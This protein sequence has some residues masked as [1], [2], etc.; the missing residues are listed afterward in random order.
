MKKTTYILAGLA[1]LLPAHVAFGAA[2]PE[3]EG[4]PPAVAGAAA[5]ADGDVEPFP[6]AKTLRQSAVIGGKTVS[7]DVTVGALPMKDEKG[8]LLGEVVYTAYTLPG[9]GAQRPVT[10][11]FN[12][13]P[14]AA[15]AY[16]NLGVLGPKVVRFGKEG[17]Y[18]SDSPA[19]RDNPNSW[20]EFTDLVF[21]DPVGTGFSRIRGDDAAA[22][23]KAFFTS[24]GD[25]QYLSR[26]IYDWLQNNGRMMSNKYLIGESYGGYRVPRIARYLQSEVGVGISGITMVSPY[27]DPSFS[28]ST[29]SFSPVPYV[30]SLPSMAATH[31]ESQGRPL[32]ASTMG[33]V[34]DYASGEFLHDYLAGAKD[35]A[36][37]ARL[38][39]KVT[40]FTGLDP[41]LVGKLDG[42]IDAR[43]FVREL[44]RDQGRI[45]SFYDPNVTTLDPYPGRKESEYDDPLLASTA[46]FSQA[47]SDL[48]VSQIGWKVNA[49]YYINNYDVN[50][51]FESDTGE[52]AVVDLRKAVGTDPRMRAT[53]VHGWNDLACPYFASKLL[54]AQMPHEG[55]EARVNLHVYPGGHMF[56]ARPDSAVAF[57][58]DMRPT[59]R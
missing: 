26:T 55:G 21:I 36:A 44:R 13:G 40:E 38:V 27:L 57:R 49:R 29:S 24:E 39:A 52:S 19:L 11:S 43:T 42:R 53:I 31:F 30:A 4:A 32:D 51:R 18:A 23:Q 37:R 7:Y 25:I 28:R 6:A 20:L 35:P 9:R 10:F 15:S 12:G 41:A 1:M 22:V 5:K 58:N 54:I 3:K 56:Y 8:K 14:G 48:V 50:R 45:G 2:A 47:M 33:A 46:P 16:L 59:Y 17:D 34:E